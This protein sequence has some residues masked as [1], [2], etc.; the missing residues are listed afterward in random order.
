[1][2]ILLLLVLLGSA[3]DYGYEDYIKVGVEQ[4]RQ[5]LNAQAIRS[6][7]KALSL[8]PD[9]ISALSLCGKAYVQ[10]GNYDRGI[11]IFRQ[12][13]PLAA[14]TGEDHFCAGFAFYKLRRM[15]AAQQQFEMAVSL[16]PNN[17]LTYV[18]LGD[19]YVQIGNTEAGINMLQKYLDRF[20]K[21]QN[22]AAV[23]KILSK[24]RQ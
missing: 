22:R 3:Q 4:F 1:M 7:E 8:K 16:I 18:Y 12:I 20:P 6:A 14:W 10:N 17:P 24:L 21:D 11:E 2:A 9:S 19:V 13:L 15:E 23:E 5:G